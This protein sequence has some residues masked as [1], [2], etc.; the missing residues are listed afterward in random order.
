MASDHTAARRVRQPISTNRATCAADPAAVAMAMVL[1]R[2]GT[3]AMTAA[4]AADGTRV[5]RQMTQP[6]NQRA[7]ASSENRVGVSQVNERVPDRTSAPST[8]S[9]TTSAPSGMASPKMP[10]PATLAKAW[11]VVSFSIV[12]VISP[13]A[14]MVRQGSASTASRLRGRQARNT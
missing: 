9:P 7:T 6:P 1:A 3:P 5:R 14:R 12:P 8:A 2:S 11:A 10:T 4:S 13:Q